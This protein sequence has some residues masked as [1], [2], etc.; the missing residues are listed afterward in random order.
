MIC[1]ITVNSVFKFTA[2]INNVVYK[3]KKKICTNIALRHTLVDCASTIYDVRSNNV[4]KSST[5]CI[6]GFVGEC[7]FRYVCGRRPGRT[8]RRFSIASR[9][10]RSVTAPMI[11][12]PPAITQMSGGSSKI[13]QPISAAQ[14]SWRKVTGCVTAT[15]AALK[16][17]VIA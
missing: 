6:R 5:K 7:Y 15:G 11:S 17:R 2:Y 4:R 3:D 14:T 1:I 13:S 10:V 8:R 9:M 16:A 12:V